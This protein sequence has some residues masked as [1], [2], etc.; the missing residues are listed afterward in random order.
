MLNRVMERMELLGVPV[1]GTDGAER[2]ESVGEIR[3][4]IVPRSSEETEEDGLDRAVQTVYAV[5]PDRYC[6]LGGFLRGMELRCAG[7]IRYRVLTP[8]RCGAWWSLKCSG[9]WL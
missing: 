3:G 4:T 5:I 6:P 8:V 2:R 1:I 7:G 9:S